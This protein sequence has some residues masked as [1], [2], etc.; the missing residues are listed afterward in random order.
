MSAIFSL[1]LGRSLVIR[2]LSMSITQPF[3][4]GKSYS[5]GSALV[6]GKD[7]HC[8]FQE[9]LQNRPGA[10]VCDADCHVT[11]GASRGLALV[12]FVSL[13]RCSSVHVIVIRR[14]LADVCNNIG[15]AGIRDID[16]F[17]KTLFLQKA[18]EP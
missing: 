17:N 8:R 18:S 13:F 11:S 3:S 5:R 9:P 4:M 2:T 12:D 6:F 14:V 1:I 16:D 15:E 10:S 7:P